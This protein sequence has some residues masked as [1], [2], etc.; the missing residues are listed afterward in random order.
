[1]RE[2]E[3]QQATDPQLMLDFVRGKISERKVRLFA[4]A[5]CRRIWHLLIDDRSRAAVE[6]EEAHADGLLSRAAHEHAWSAAYGVLET[7]GAGLQASETTIPASTAAASLGAPFLSTTLAVELAATEAAAAT[8][9]HA[10]ESIRGGAKELA[11]AKA[12]AA[13]FAAQAELMRCISGPLPFRS[14]TIQAGWLRWNAGIAPAIARRIYAE[15][16]FEDL[17]ILADALEDAGCDQPDILSH[18]RSN[19]LHARG[20]W[21]VD[22]LLGKS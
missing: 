13:E 7:A 22:L 10:V 17:P 19:G 18:C 9:S 2:T 1:M 4:A 6:A 5:C 14:V 20:C 8:A 15:R 11:A 21:V 12:R 3:W 16:T